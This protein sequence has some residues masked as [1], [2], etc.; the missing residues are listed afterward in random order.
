MA[1]AAS[2]HLVEGFGQAD[3]AFAF[4]RVL[5][6]AGAAATGM[7]LGFYDINRPGELFSGF[8]RFLGGPG[9]IA[10]QYR[11]AIGLEQFLALVFMY[12]HVESAYLFL[13]LKWRRRGVL[14]Q[15]FRDRARTDVTRLRKR[16]LHVKMRQLRDR[17]SLCISSRREAVVRKF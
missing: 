5:E 2:L 3:A 15:S 13:E 1:A 8:N 7:D 9:D 6:L 11:N 16:Q 17:S 14:L 4:R 12:V 10:V